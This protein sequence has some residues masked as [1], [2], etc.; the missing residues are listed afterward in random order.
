V[1]DGTLYFSTFAAAPPGTL[2][3]SNGVAKL[4]GRDFV[5]P[6]DLTCATGNT[7]NRSLGGIPELQPPPPNAPQSPAPSFIEPD[8]YD[9]TLAGKVIPGVSINATPVCASLGT[10]GN[11]SYVAG[12]SHAT[13]QNYTQPG[14]FSL[15]TQVG[16]KGSNGSTTKQ[17]QM[18]V[19][20]PVSPT[21]IDSWAA[22]LE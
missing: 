12:A 20:T 13:P 17:F 8:L 16:T 10:P 11:D 18:A 5:T 4:W 7:C 15:F 2:S 21:L 14:G 3:C 22:V 6:A 19:P 1:F 9:T